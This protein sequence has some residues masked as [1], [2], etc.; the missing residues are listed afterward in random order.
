MGGTRQCESHVGARSGCTTERERGP[1]GH[2]RWLLTGINSHTH[3]GATASAADPPAQILPA[4]QHCRLRPMPHPPRAGVAAQ[5]PPWPL[6]L[7]LTTYAPSLKWCK[8]SMHQCSAAMSPWAAAT[9][10][11]ILLHRHPSHIPPIPCKLLTLQLS[12]QQT[13]EHS[14]WA[15]PWGRC[16]FGPTSTLQVQWQLFMN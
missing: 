10:A 16:A 15:W 12:R 5:L 7:F 2:I 1:G 8:N 11:P 14:C 4:G 13:L 3:I 9:C 6:P